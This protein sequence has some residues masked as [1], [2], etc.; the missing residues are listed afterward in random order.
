MNRDW[1]NFKFKNDQERNSFITLSS[2]V[3]IGRK[4]LS[5]LIFIRIKTG[6]SFGQILGLKIPSIYRKCLTESQINSINIFLNEQK[7]YSFIE[8]LKTESITA[9]TIF[10]PIYPR[11]LKESD[12]PPLVFYYRGDLDLLKSEKW[13]AM[14]GTRRMTAYGS[15]AARYLASEFVALGWGIVSG[16]MYGIDTASHQACLDAGGKTIGVLGYGFGFKSSRSAAELEA[17][18]I[19]GG[20]GLISEF[21]PGTPAQ[22]GHFP[23]RNRIVAGLCQAVIVV[24]AAQ[25]SGSHITAQCG[26]DA[27]R[28]VGAVPGPITSPYSRGTKSL[29]NQGAV[30]IGCA[31]DVLQELNYFEADQQIA[32]HISQ[33]SDLPFAKKSLESEIYDMLRTAPCSTQAVAGQ[34]TKSFSE[35][36]ASLTNLEV[37]GLIDRTDTMWR[38]VL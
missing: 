5:D 9:I 1:F 25:K 19:S 26:L 7:V 34:V 13:I 2:I 33:T 32:G 12:D 16:C 29:I 8:Q 4:T 37:A 36:M 21:A 31:A 10:D 11:L 18:I 22:A 30:C 24:E 15:Q 17:Q 3:G 27:G 28:V 35:V 14:V 23:L 38:I 20:G 6:I